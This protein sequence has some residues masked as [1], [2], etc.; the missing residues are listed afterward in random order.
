V[1]TSFPSNLDSL[2]NPSATNPLS[3]PSHSDQHINAN[4]AIEALETKV[5][6]NGS[7]DSNSLDYKVTQLQ[8]SGSSRVSAVLGLEGNN[9]LTI[10]GIE[11]ATT[12]DSLDSSIWRSATYELQ[13]TK[14]TDVYSSV[15]KVLFGST[16]N[17]TETNIVTT[18]DNLANPASLDFTTSG[19]IIS[20]V[21]TPIAGS[22]SVRFIRTAIKK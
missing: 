14:G 9:D 19:S 10:N 11:N 8:A 7:T 20:L 2:V 5:G 15:V 17:A 4:D 16:I 3:N 12:I 18:S 22:V 13:I 6:V 1:A 21:V